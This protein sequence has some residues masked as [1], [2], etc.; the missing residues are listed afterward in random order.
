MIKK[1][2]SLIQLKKDYEFLKQK[3][4][5]LNRKISQLE[6]LLCVTECKLKSEFFMIFEQEKM[7]NYELQEALQKELDEYEKGEELKKQNYTHEVVF[8]EKAYKTRYVTEK[9]FNE[10]KRVLATTKNNELYVDVAGDLFKIKDI[11]IVCKIK[12][13]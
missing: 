4:E 1:I 13:K 10:I 5:R 8:K 3:N 9:Q 2:K 6:E 11:E 12:G 7:R